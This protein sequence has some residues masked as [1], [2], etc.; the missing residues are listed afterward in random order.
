MNQLS[1]KKLSAENSPVTGVGAPD[2]HRLGARSSRADVT[3]AIRL[4]TSKC[5][6]VGTRSKLQGQ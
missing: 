4:W 5:V 2:T 1:T 3:T 6:A